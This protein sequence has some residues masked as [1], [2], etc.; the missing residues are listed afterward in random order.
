MQGFDIKERIMQ[1][2]NSICN[3]CEFIGNCSVSEEDKFTDDIT[4]CVIDCVHYEKTD[5]KYLI[6]ARDT[7]DGHVVRQFYSD[8]IP[9][10]E[11][12]SRFVKPTY[13][14]LTA[15]IRLKN[16]NVDASAFLDFYE[17]VGWKIGNKPMKDWKAACRTWSRREVSKPKK[18]GTISRPPS[19]DLN[20]IAARA[21][22]N[23][24]IK[25]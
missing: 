4:N 17:S 15:Y 11:K 21:R 23:T 7:E 13:D 22:N 14:E 25:Y 16:L 20:D 2:N 12:S 6:T 9:K 5:K 19:Y 8:K 18:Q 24:D 1:M 3:T 10:A